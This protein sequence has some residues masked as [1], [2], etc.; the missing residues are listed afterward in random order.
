MTT[1]RYLAAPSA[2]LFLSACQGPLPARTVPAQGVP[3][4]VGQVSFDAPQRV[5]ATFPEVTTEAIV[6]LIDA[7]TGN[8]LGS[9]ITNSSGGF[10][11][12]FN[13]FTPS[14]GTA[15]I[16]EAV[17]GLSV[18][19]SPNRAGAPAV[20]L[21]SY[22][23]WNAGWQSFTNTTLNT[24]IMLGNATTALSA[25]VSLKQQA[26][27]SLTLAN[28][29][30]KVN[31][32]GDA[33]TEAG[34]GLSNANDFLAVLALVGNAITL[35]QDPLG[36]IGYNRTNGT[37]ALST[38][39]PW[40]GSYSPTI[41]TP[42][43]TVTLRGANLDQLAGRNVF[44]FGPIAA[45]TWSVGPDRKTATVTIPAGAYSAPFRLQQ[46]NGL[47]QTIAPFLK[48]HG[49]VGT[50]AG[51]GYVGM[52]DGT[53]NS[54]AFWRPIG[55][56]FDLNGNLLV[57]DNENHRICRV[58]TAGKVTTIAGGTGT[59]T[60]DGPV[61]LAKFGGPRA[62]TVDRF[63]NIYLGDTNNG[64][65]RRITVTGQVE[66]L[67][68]A[69]TFAQNPAN[70][71]PFS[72]N[73]G[74]LLDP[75]GNLYIADT[76]GNRIWKANAGGGLAVFAGDGTKAELDGTGLGARFS[77]PY[78]L[79]MDRAGNLYAAD[80][81]GRI[82]KITPAGVVTTLATAGGFALN[83]VSPATFSVS[84]NVTTDAND[85]LFIA[86]AGTNLFTKV[87]PA[88]VISLINGNTVTGNKDGSL[89]TAQ[90]GGGPNGIVLDADGTIYNTDTENHQ[91][92]VL[93][94]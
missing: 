88:G 16:L 52:T 12:T 65:V 8:T 45:S 5:Q 15:Y 38:G 67:T 41:P 23:Y 36:A 79:G 17:K 2:F 24:G 49:T 57:C 34:T 85:N 61:A 50:L 83:P 72:A 37:Y 86:D 1:F 58:T 64:L 6:S 90:F 47:F 55:I 80:W 69:G 87:T 35:D 74:V 33:F 22:L 31:E 82:R 42:G 63:G 60:L 51:S 32:T 93:V 44:W 54:A 43:G 77:Q 7:G 39:A 9:S 20:R 19:G 30:G 94:P 14:N 73:R 75:A 46:P 13:G 84:L 26:G 70:P 56:T 68:T 53:G 18:G 29:I 91:I 25:V 59:G 10:V 28:L 71:A 92:R 62:I 40:V 78:H 48:L 21:R 81:A 3:P 89:A 76:D 11:L 66:T 4:V 27:V